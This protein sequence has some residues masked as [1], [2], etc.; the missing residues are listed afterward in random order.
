[1]NELIRYTCRGDPR[2]TEHVTAVQDFYHSVTHNSQN[3]AKRYDCLDSSVDYEH[4][5]HHSNT[6]HEAIDSHNSKWIPDVHHVVSTFNHNSYCR[7]EV[8]RWVEAIQCDNVTNKNHA[9]V[10]L[11]G[12][13]R[14]NHFNDNNIKSYIQGNMNEICRQEI[15]TW[16]EGN[17]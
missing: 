7:E 3:E 9:I 6:V 15:Y 14:H 10:L 13:I 12:L 4:V 17:V 1:M 11:N 5:R 8:L 2:S 16:I